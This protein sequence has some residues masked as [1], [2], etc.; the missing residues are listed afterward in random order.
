[1][2]AIKEDVQWERVAAATAL[3]DDI[4][5]LEMPL[6]GMQM[7]LS[8]MMNDDDNKLIC[9]IQAEHRHA[10]DIMA[11]MIRLALLAPNK[12]TTAGL[13]SS[14]PPRASFLC[15]PLQPQHNKLGPFC[16][17][18]FSLYQLRGAAE[19]LLLVANNANKKIAPAATPAAQ[20]EASIDDG[21]PHHQSTT[22]KG[23]KLVAAAKCGFSLGLAVLLGLLFSNDH[24]FWSGLI[25]HRDG[26]RIHLY[27]WPFDTRPMC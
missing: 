13:W 1:M 10:R 18:L 8:M 26:P 25:H 11:M 6:A 23:N 5:M 21:H 2:S 19:G 17:F 27:R 24:G 22:T 14:K 12:Q 3:D 4:S 7:A 20:Q 9:P 15:L 16:L